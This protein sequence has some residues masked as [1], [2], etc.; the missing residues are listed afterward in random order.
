MQTWI[1]DSNF[2]KSA[3]NLDKKRLHSQIYEGIHILASLLNCN[4]K[5]INPKRSVKNHPAAK[6]WS[7]YEN[8]LFN[9]ID[10]HMAVID[11]CYIIKNN[12]NTLNLLLLVDI[13]KFHINEQFVIPN[14]ITPELIRVHRSVLIQKKPEYY[15]EKW[16][17]IPDNLEMR[18]NWR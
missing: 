15:R 17:D 1:T 13:G 16:P 7:G 2:L 6:L 12:I 4:N 5:L 8:E 11:P 9:Y 18:Y 14:W 10:I 3:K